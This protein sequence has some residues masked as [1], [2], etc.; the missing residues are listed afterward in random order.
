MGYEAYRDRSVIGKVIELSGK[1]DSLAVEVNNIKEDVREI[2]ANVSTKDVVSM[3]AEDLKEIKTTIATK[4]E[5]SG[6]I[7]ELKSDCRELNKKV[8]ETIVTKGVFWTGVGLV[9]GSLALLLTAFG[10][11]INLLR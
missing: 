9:I 6:Q 7:E 5:V 10:I 11:I 3:L 4:E 2:K 1:V 8:D